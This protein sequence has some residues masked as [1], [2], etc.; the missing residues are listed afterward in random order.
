MKEIVENSTYLNRFGKTRDEIKEKIIERKKRFN[1]I[2][3]ERLVDIEYKEKKED[4]IRDIKER[5]ENLLIKNKT[6][7]LL[8]EENFIEKEDF[9]KFSDDSLIMLIYKCKF[10]KYRQILDF[11]ANK[12]KLKTLYNKVSKL[13]RKNFLETIKSPFEDTYIQDLENENKFSKNTIIFLAPDSLDTVLSL[14]NIENRKEMQK[15][16]DK[17]NSNYE[18]L[19][20][21]NDKNYY[22][23]LPHTFITNE[24]LLQII[25]VDNESINFKLVN[26]EV[27]PRPK[28]AGFDGQ[29]VVR[30]IKPDLI[31]EFAIYSKVVG[32]WTNFHFILENDLGTKMGTSFKNKIKR[33][34]QFFESGAYMRYFPKFVKPGVLFV[35]KDVDETR[36]Y[37]IIDVIKE[38][39]DE[40]LDLYDFYVTNFNYFKANIF[41]IWLKAGYET[42]KDGIIRFSNITKCKRA[43]YH[44]K[45]TDENWEDI[46]F[47]DM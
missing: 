13:K 30:R 14:L 32:S 21:I 3:H 4:M 37:Y 46:E 12:I 16:K 18:K 5:E 8:T 33:Y 36:S 44:P 20:N 11:Y 26:W 22:G 27:E 29:G 17:I 43:I 10:L 1:L 34:K 38:V 24:I 15:I 2:T 42:K 9:K 6:D 25:K 39:L 45:K 28:Y 47:E 41:K 23:S 35:V 31:I 40:D 7:I 19:I